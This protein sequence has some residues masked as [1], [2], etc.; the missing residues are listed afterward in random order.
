MKGHLENVIE[1]L[2]GR[3]LP[4]GMMKDGILVKKQLKHF[5]KMATKCKHPAPGIISGLVQVC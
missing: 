5:G 2:R 1:V 4:T 3:W